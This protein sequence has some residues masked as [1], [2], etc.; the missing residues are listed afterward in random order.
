MRHVAT[1]SLAWALAAAFAL[2]ADRVETL[3]ARQIDGEVLSITAD[4]VVVKTSQGKQSLSRNEV[5]EI[6]LA[7]APELMERRNQGV[8]V[9]H[10]GD[11]IA[12]GTLLLEEGKF[13]FD[14]A[15]LGGCQLEIGAVGLV[16]QPNAR[17]SAAQIEEKCKELRI[18]TSTQ[19]TLV[20]AQKDGAWL[21]VEG[22]LKTVD[23]QAGKIGF[24][25]KDEDK[26]LASNLV[27]A[28]RMAAI[29]GKQP[30]RSGVL[31]GKC[32]TTIG[33]SSLTMDDKSLAVSVAGL[34]ERKVPRDAVAAIRLKS[35]NSVNLTDLTPAE[36]KEHGFF[37]TE[38][39]FPYRAN[40]SI[41]GQELRLGGRTYRTGLGLHSFC[42]LTYRI[43][44]AYST[45]VATV[46]IDDAARPG[47]N[48]VL[49]VLADGKNLGE[50]L[51]LTGKSDPAAVRADVKGVKQ[52]T[53]RVDFGE[54]GLGV[55]DHVDIVAARLIK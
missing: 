51:R 50:P 39:P 43:D 7:D 24:R 35:T 20:V 25:W 1:T 49:T 18:A 2:G 52:L 34:G 55:S 21:G 31:V 22:V 23:P 3:D 42:E 45:F 27:V 11:R 40:R 13:S 36:V 46:G 48:A 37:Q 30:E 8:L 32:G 28:I 9:T 29:A 26:K 41:S 33:F 10:G 44:G 5:A 53:L 4:Q 14:T 12:F 6:S 47:G 38:T 19:D 15:M 54:G 17:L 16:Y